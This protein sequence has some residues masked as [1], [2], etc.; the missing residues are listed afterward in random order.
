[1]IKASLRRY[2]TVSAAGWRLR[3]NGCA[4]VS[5]GTN[6]LTSIQVL[7]TNSRMNRQL[8]LAPRPLVCLHKLKLPDE[9]WD[10][11]DHKTVSNC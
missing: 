7:Q 5:S 6:K 8:G 11:F 2:R 4:P 3:A 9:R 10:Q 1:M